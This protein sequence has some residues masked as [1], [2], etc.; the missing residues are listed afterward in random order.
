[1]DDYKSHQI[2]PIR[3][4]HARDDVSRLSAALGRSARTP[5]RRHMRG[6]RLGAWWARAGVSVWLSPLL[7]GQA[8]VDD[9]GRAE[10]S[11]LGRRSHSQ[12][13][14]GEVCGVWSTFKCQ[15]M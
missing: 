2:D 15:Y 6:Q 5:E 10:V 11:S 1:M 7:R 14:L 4:A 8:G 13:D 12:G 9:G 3:C